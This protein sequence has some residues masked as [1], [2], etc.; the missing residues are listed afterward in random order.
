MADTARSPLRALA[1]DP[2]LRRA[3]AALALYRLAEFG[4][5]VAMLVFAF[6]QGGATATGVV[7]FALL[8]PT[9]IF[10]PF[11]GPLIDRFGASRVLLGAYLTQGVAMGATAASLLAGAP[12]GLTYALG[13]LTATVLT[14]THPAHAVMSPGIAR[15]AGQLVALNAIT[16]WILSVGLVAAPALA[17]VILEIST[18][19]AVYA[20]GAFCLAVSALLVLPLRDLAHPL[21]RDG[22]ASGEGVIGRLGQGAVALARPSPSREV[23]VVLAATF[24]MV[25]AFDVLAVVLAVGTLDIGG[26]G[27]GYLTAAHGAGAVVGAVVSLSLAR[28]ARLVPV[29][30]VAAALAG[31]AFLVLGLALTLVVAFAAAAASGLSRSLLE[32]SGQ[33]L[34][35][36]V[37]A[38]DLLARVFAFKE[39]LAMAAWGIG[40]VA[41]PVVIAVAGVRG[42]LLVGG[43]VVPVVVL[44]RLRSLLAADAAVVVPAVTIALFRSLGVFRALPVPALE[45]VAH[46][47]TTVSFPAGAR[48]VTQGEQGDRYYAI[49]DGT[50]EVLVDGRPTGTLGRGEGFGEIAL[51]HRVPRTATVVAVTDCSLVAVDQ[52]PFLVAVTGHSPTRERI[53]VVAAQRLAP[54]LRAIQ[55]RGSG[56]AG[57]AVLLLGEHVPVGNLPGVVDRRARRPHRV[58]DRCARPRL[59]RAPWNPAAQQAGSGLRAVEGEDGEL[60]SADPRDDVAPAYR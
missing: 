18:P 13:A 36:R 9:A 11:A 41:V 54:G 6:E 25:G 21:P 8:V 22:E 27:A 32:V 50:V 7:S 16:G 59:R 38:T 15:T 33:T 19:G 52:E 46:G 31:A 2:V 12:P 10:A 26:S 23:V 24:L 29:V 60:V 35:Q 43:A 51:L 56:C 42:A 39:G 17:G 34:L 14:V 3:A 45:G 4:P 5:W 37:T 44:L 30:A 1:G 55:G 28:R 53:E 48:I 20:A 58:A 47:A 57:G 40:S 49:A